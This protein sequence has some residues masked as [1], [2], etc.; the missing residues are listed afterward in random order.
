MAQ[1]VQGMLESPCLEG[2]GDVAPGDMVSGHGGSGVWLGLGVSEVLSSLN[3]SMI[4]YS[5]WAEC[6]TPKH[7]QI[8]AYLLFQETC[9]LFHCFSLLFPVC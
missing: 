2:C 4:L 7:Y 1:A 9:R 8:A 6:G 5:P 3:E